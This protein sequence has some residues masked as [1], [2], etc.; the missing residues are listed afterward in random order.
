[1]I[2]IKDVI[3]LTIFETLETILFYMLFMINQDNIL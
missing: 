1:M 2:S 3:D